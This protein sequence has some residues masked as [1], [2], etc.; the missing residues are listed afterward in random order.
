[1][2]AGLYRCAGAD[3]AVNPFFMVNRYSYL[4]PA[5]LKEQVSPEKAVSSVWFGD[6]ERPL[7]YRDHV[8][9]ETYTLPSGS[10]RF[11]LALGSLDP[12]HLC[13]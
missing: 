2:S 4:T 12:C 5:K 8:T 7:G 13:V 9:T 11:R 6:C 3:A 10:L 1:M